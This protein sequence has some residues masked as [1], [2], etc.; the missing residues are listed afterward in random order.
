MDLRRR[1]AAAGALTGIDVLDHLVLGDARYGSFKE[2]GRPGSVVPSPP[3]ANAQNLTPTT[4]IRVLNPLQV[5]TSK[6]KSA[7]L[8]LGRYRVELR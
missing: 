4:A 6:V 5:E 2:S 8:V 1:L 3:A 7:S